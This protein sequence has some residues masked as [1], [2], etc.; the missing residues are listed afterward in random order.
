MK[1]FP[2]KRDFFYIVG[3]L[4]ITIIFIIS[5]RLPHEAD[6]VDY[7]GFAGTIV[8]ILLA[9]VAI[10]YSFYQSSTYE[11]VNSKL[12]NSAHKIEKATQE[13]SDVSEIK[14]LIDEFK[15]EVS[16]IKTSMVGLNEVVSTIDNQVTHINKNWEETKTNIMKT[17]TVNKEVSVEN[18]SFLT[19]EYFE[20]LLGN[21]GILQIYSL[22]VIDRKLASNNKVIDLN[23]FNKIYVKEILKYDKDE[24]DKRYF[25]N[26]LY[27]Q[28][29]FIMG[30]KMAGFIGMKNNTLGTIEVKH[31]NPE[32]SKALNEKVNTYKVN[33]TERYN[34]FKQVEKAIREES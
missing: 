1:G 23:K 14:G 31:I 4:I 2:N 3:F 7:V 33:D 21:G 15:D 27:V 19:K 34:G 6:I 22:Y 24:D 18:E 32:L 30:Y 5:G 11:N 29:G 10:I 20:K 12:D 16:E 28:V 25:D 13:L 8:S 17:V 26:I 9:V